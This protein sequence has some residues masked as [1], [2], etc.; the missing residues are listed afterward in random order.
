MTCFQPWPSQDAQQLTPPVRFG[1]PE[2]SW[3]A[4][5]PLPRVKT[6]WG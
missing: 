2:R 3:V 5:R 6:A 4:D 1:Q